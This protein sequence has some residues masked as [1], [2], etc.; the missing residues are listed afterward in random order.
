MSRL[1]SLGLSWLK[2][3]TLGLSLLGS[4]SF[5]AKHEN[6]EFTQGLVKSSQISL[7][8]LN[9]CNPNYWSVLPS[10]VISYD[11]MIQLHFS[12]SWRLTLMGM[13]AKWLGRASMD[14]RRWMAARRR[15]ALLMYPALNFTCNRIISLKNRQSTFL[16]LF[17]I[18][19]C[20]F[21]IIFASNIMTLLSP[22]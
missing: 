7:W 3:L 8:I 17:H 10:S 21:K 11:E 20:L 6:Q 13:L 4:S 9:H 14:W 5:K 22:I 15:S 1:T 2:L 16:L 12:S 18:D 19:D